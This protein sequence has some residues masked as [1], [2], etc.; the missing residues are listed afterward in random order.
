[1]TPNHWKN[2]DSRVGDLPSVPAG[3]AYAPALEERITAMREM[4]DHL[5]PGSDAEALGLLRAA[6]PEVSLAERV[7]VL[8]RGGDR[9]A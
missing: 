1:M 3:R 9:E 5:R 8:T 7:A 2:R 4:L 6:F